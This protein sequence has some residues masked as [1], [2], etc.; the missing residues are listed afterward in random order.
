[1]LIAALLSF[2]CLCLGAGDSLF[3]ADPFDSNAL[4][5]SS[6]GAGIHSPADATPCLSHHG[7]QEPWD[8]A[9]VLDQALCHHPKTR[10]AWANARYQASQVGLAQAA[11]LPTLNLSATGARSQNSSS[12]LG[13]NSSLVSG[14]SQSSGSSG[15]QFRIAPQV[16][17]NYLLY[18][19]GNR[20]AKLDN[21]RHALEAANWS[22]D[23]SLQTVLL[24]AVQA[25]YQVFATRSAVESA[26]VSLNSSERALQ[27]AKTRHEVGSAALADALQAQ[28]TYD[29]ARVTLRKAEGDAQI[30]LGNLANAM[31]LE[32]DQRLSIAAPQFASPDAQHERDVHA[33]IAEARRLR[34]DLAAA[35]EQLQAAE[36]GVQTA[37][38]GGLPSV[39]LVSN[40]GYSASSLTRDTQSWSVGLQL[41]VP[42]FTGFTN[43][44]QI[45]SAEALVDV[46][47]ANREQLDQNVSLDVWRAYQNLNTARETLQGTESL[48]ASSSQSEQVAQGRYQAGAGNILDLLSAQAS[49]AAARLQRIQAQYT[50]LTQKAQLAQAIGRLDL[51]ALRSTDSPP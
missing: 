22:H 33:L 4:S 45:R 46:Q 28:T 5:G 51:Q 38:A 6:P 41:S 17:L 30:A 31:G 43:T 36:A 32:A 39:S 47:K 50:W 9:E 10:L 19:F 37:R 8:L 11:Y 15:E 35:A 1:M 23:A 40:Y 21:A 2:P 48:V 12:S 49:L 34:P 13:S 29:Q 14:L 27:A 20:A 7:D 16:T 25:Y 24:G 26:Q 42:L 44:Y 18:D 3:P